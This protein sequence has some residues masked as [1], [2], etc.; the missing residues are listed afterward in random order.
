[1]SGI[2]GVSLCYWCRVSL[3]NDTKQIWSRGLKWG[4]NNLH[5]CMALIICRLI[6]FVHWAGRPALTVS[7][8]GCLELSASLTSLLR[9]RMSVGLAF[10]LKLWSRSRLSAPAEIIFSLLEA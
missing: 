9:C 7:L 4:C 6:S 3:E 5:W 1:M 10:V 2:F 8:I